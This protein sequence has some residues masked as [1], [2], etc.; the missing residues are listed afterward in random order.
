MISVI[1]PVYNAEKYLKQCLQSVLGQTYK[2]IEVILVNDGSKDRSYVVC[3]EYAGKDNRIKL[4]NKENGGVVAAWNAG[5]SVASGE[6]IAFVD[7]DD[8]V[9]NTY[10][11]TLLSGMT[12]NVDLVAMDCIRYVSEKRYSYYEIN[13]LSE[14]IYEIDSSFLCRLISDYGSYKRIVAGSRW[15]KLIRTD[16]VKRYAQYCSTDVSYGED[17]QL[18]IGCLIGSRKIR[19]QKVAKY[20]YRNNQTSIVNSYKKN[21]FAKSKTL[22]DVICNI[23]GVKSIPNAEKQIN[24]LFVLY[25]NDCIKNEV[26]FRTDKC[27]DKV[28]AFLIDERYQRALTDMYTDEMGRLDKKI[29]KHCVNKSYIGIRFTLLIYKI[30]CI[31]MN[32]SYI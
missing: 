29:V 8:F 11:Q 26:F 25:V 22:I 10:L 20:Y 6:Y 18:I 27:K 13:T 31:L 30:Y 24:T 5:L 3:E 23:P 14:G 9:D 17:L 16:I 15:G 7:S 19:I 12:E 32:K 21:L 2:D 4:I 28:V 1:I